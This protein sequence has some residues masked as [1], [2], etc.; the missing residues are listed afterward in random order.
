MNYTYKIDKRIVIESAIMGSIHWDLE[1]LK[2]YSYQDH[3]YT[4]KDS[5]LRTQKWIYENYPELL[6]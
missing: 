3:L 1:S 4:Y 2:K 5:F 6:L